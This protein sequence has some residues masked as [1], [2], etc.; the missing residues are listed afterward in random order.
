MNISG[1]YTPTKWDEFDYQIISDGM[2]T[3]K[4]SVEFQFAGDIEGL[5]TVEYLMFYTSFNPDDLHKSEAV[6]VGQIHIVGTLKGKVGSFALNDSGT[7]TSG[8][9]HSRIMIIQG[10]GTGELA[11]ISGVGNYAAN[12]H[13]CAWEMDINL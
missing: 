13:G 7:F 5:A 2:K 4:A 12:Q 11:T 8:V 1:T 3:T 10:S 6:Y 9:A